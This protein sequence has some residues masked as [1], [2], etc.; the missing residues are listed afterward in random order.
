MPFQGLTDEQAALNYTLLYQDQPQ[1]PSHTSD[2][3][4]LTLLPGLFEQRIVCLLARGSLGTDGYEAL[5]YTW[6]ECGPTRPSGPEWDSEFGSECEWE[7]VDDDDDDAAEENDNDKHCAD[8][9][10][11]EDSI[12]EPALSDADAPTIGIAPEIIVVNS[13]QISV[14]PNL[15]TALHYLRYEDRPRTLWIDYLCINQRS[16][17]DRNAQVPRMDQIYRSASQVV[18]WLG[19]ADAE[20]EVATQTIHN[21]TTNSH[22]SQTYELF[23]SVKGMVNL[24]SRSWYKRAW[25]V[26]EVALAQRAVVQ[27]GERILPWDWFS[28]AAR[29]HQ[30]HQ[31]CCADKVHPFVNNRGGDYFLNLREAWASIL[32]LDVGAKQPHCSLH[33]LLRLYW[34]RLATDPRDKIYAFLGLLEP[35]QR[36]VVPDYALSTR[37]VYQDAVVKIINHSSDLSI[38][39]DKDEY[40]GEVDV[41]TWCTDW[42]STGVSGV[43]LYSHYQAA[44]NSEALVQLCAEDTLKVQGLVYDTITKIAPD[45]G[46]SEVGTVLDEAYRILCGWESLCQLSAGSDI[47]YPSGGTRKDAFWQTVLMGMRADR[48]ARLSDAD[49]VPYNTWRQWLERNH[50]RAPYTNEAATL[51]SRAWKKKVQVNANS[52]IRSHNNIVINYPLVRW[53]FVTE[54]GYIGL[55]PAKMQPGDVVCVLRGGKVPFVLRAA[56]EDGENDDNHGDGPCRAAGA[57]A[58]EQGYYSLVGYAYLHGVMD[59]EAVRVVERGEEEWMDFW[60]R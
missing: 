18:I 38:L 26:Q 46:A 6:G 41:P 2:V 57:C 50:G 51:V 31:F 52:S 19:V 5:S 8:G 14:M 35:S 23:E 21:L 30:A 53:F 1:L 20:S 32:A 37:K 28:Q 43:E 47:L 16:N 9:N 33:F 54:R 12:K 13:I 48:T 4:L 49:R 44:G 60:L 59:G 45:E 17:A 29:V 24:F 10:Q 58:A 36:L 15:G 56:E 55:G 34:S 3:R 39:M 25:V 40:L 22:L 27:L 7:D 42:T 11:S